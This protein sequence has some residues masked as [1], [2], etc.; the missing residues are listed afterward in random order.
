LIWR[1]PKRG[2]QAWNLLA[3]AS[4]A[5]SLATDGR[6]LFW[7]S[8]D[9]IQVTPVDGTGSPQTLLADPF[10][11]NSIALAGDSL[12]YVRVPLSPQ[13]L[14]VRRMPKAGGA[15]QEI[16]ALPANSSTENITIGAGDANV[17]FDAGDS[18]DGI[19]SVS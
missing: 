9:G 5:S 16:A 14:S 1:I 12:F 18:S 11:V 4:N 7:V 8:W 19:Y 17:F 2:S 13:A 10:H 15:W 3:S 6:L